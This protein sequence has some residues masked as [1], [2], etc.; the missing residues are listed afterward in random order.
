MLRD[1]DGVLDQVLNP[2][3]VEC[4]LSMTC[5]VLEVG[6]DDQCSL[7]Y[8]HC[9]H[10]LLAVRLGLAFNDTD[11]PFWAGADT[12]PKPVTEKVAH[13]PGLPV[14]ELECSLRAIRD[15][16]AA[17]RAF[18]IVNADNPALHG[19]FSRQL[20]GRAVVIRV[21]DRA[22][23]YTQAWGQSVLS[24]CG[25]IYRHLVKYRGDT[26]MKSVLPVH[27]V[28]LSQQDPPSSGSFAV[29]TGR[30]ATAGEQAVHG[31]YSALG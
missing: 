22:G 28:L 26:G 24:V 3:I 6:F 8:D 14:N 1:R 4:P 19:S 2:L 5:Q 11:R 30:Q 27:P 21:L 20:S 31:N 18:R 23:I 17:S 12:G 9:H 10:G 13:E 16:L 15:A 25:C 7:F 29:H